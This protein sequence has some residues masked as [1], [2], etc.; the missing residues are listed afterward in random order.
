[1][2][3]PI[4][5][6]SNYLSVSFMNVLPENGTAAMEE[7]AKLKQQ[8]VWLNIDYQNIDTLAWQQIS[9]LTNLRKLSVKNSNLDDDKMNYF[10]TLDSLVSLNLV[11]TKVSLPGLV[12]IK[13]L[14][15]L[16]SIYIYQ[17]NVDET[18][19]SQLKMLFPLATIDFGY[20]EVPILQSD[21]TIFKL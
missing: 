10:E 21:T 13:T 19:F 11:G 1:M 6:N 20:Y 7:C 18:G 12:K 3:S 4:A 14:Q 16:E 15:N 17:T 5:L 9:L 8:I 2:L